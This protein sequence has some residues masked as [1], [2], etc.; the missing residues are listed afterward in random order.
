MASSHV[1]ENLKSESDVMDVVRAVQAMNAA[2]NTIAKMEFEAR[3]AMVLGTLVRF[4]EALRAAH[5]RG[6]EALADEHSFLSQFVQG[7]GAPAKRVLE[8]TVP[9]AIRLMDKIHRHVSQDLEQNGAFFPASGPAAIFLGW[10]DP[11]ISFVRKV[12]LLFAT[13]N[14]VCV[15][16]SRSSAR[17]LWAV[18]ELWLKALEDSGTPAGVFSVL[19]GSGAGQETIGELLLKHPSFKNI[20]WIGRSESALL[21]RPIALEAGKRFYFFGSGRNPAI[22][23]APAQG[24]DLSSDQ[25]LESTL[26]D[27]VGLAKDPHGWGPYRPSRLFIQ[28]SVYKK[29]LEILQAELE[30]S[31]LGDPRD[32]ETDLGPIPKSSVERF[33]SQLKL[34]LSE[35]GKLVT[36]GDVRGD[37][38]VRPTLVRDLTNCSTLQGEELEGVF[39]T[40]ASFKYQ[41]EAVKY[42]N[43]S[44]L[45]LAGF[46]FHPDL[47]K[48]KALASRLEVSR[49]IVTGKPDRAELMALA[50]SAVK[51]SASAPDG[52][53]ET[54]EQGRFRPSIL[55]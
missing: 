30:V 45:G 35:T 36:G 53:L 26:M 44:P 55:A 31:R 4:Q 46:V 48:A 21:A 33:Q 18:S 43:T 3:K 32:M 29:S 25:V 52:L 1:F 11:L 28:E 2:N 38:L 19:L 9:T 34:A 10:S 17:A 49:L 37:G 14:G 39:L 15:K 41:H 51:N 23:F 5:L 24:A 8:E 42:A 22:L 16:P 20:H 54:Y 50:A 7:S 13:G 47:E 6:H 40:A 12:P 27:I